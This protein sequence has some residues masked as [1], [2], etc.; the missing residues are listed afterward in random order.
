MDKKSRI[1]EAAKELMSQKGYESTTVRDIST[2]ADVN[3]AMI[4]YY[5]GSKE[6]LFAA[7]IEENAGNALNKLAYIGSTNSTPEKKIEALVT[8]YVERI[9]SN[10]SFYSILNRELSSGHSK[11]LHDHIIAVHTKNFNS[12]KKIITD[13]QRDK[14]FKEDIDLDLTMATFLGTIS[15]I[16][17]PGKLLHRIYKLKFSGSKSDLE[18]DEALK[19]RLKAHLTDLLQLYL[20]KK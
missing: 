14:Y 5:F 20:I 19:I 18:K 17:N 16:T 10:R 15:E 9:F 13:G 11:E 2:M 1:L 8:L 7:M 12:F 3:V 6:K 4:S